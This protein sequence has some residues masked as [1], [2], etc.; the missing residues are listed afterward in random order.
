MID[1]IMRAQLREAMESRF[2]DGL[3]KKAGGLQSLGKMIMVLRKSG[4]NASRLAGLEAKLLGKV[5]K[6]G[7]KKFNEHGVAALSGKKAGRVLGE[8][9][10][11]VRAVG[12]TRAARRGT[13]EGYRTALSQ[14][15]RPL[16]AK[17][18]TPGGYM[19]RALRSRQQVGF[20][21]AAGLNPNMPQAARQYA[22]NRANPQ[23]MAGRMRQGLGQSRGIPGAPRP[24]QGFMSGAMQGM[25]NTMA[26]PGFWP[27]AGMGAAAAGGAM[28]LGGAIGGRR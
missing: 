18:K 7:M 13:R 28:M 22:V 26:K 25:H 15:T 27:A 11:K 4:A 16:G 23:F 10:K 9:G 1:P 21:S 8:S 19:D 20:R 17:S 6:A 12:T 2:G 3:E 14:T 5:G 24:Q